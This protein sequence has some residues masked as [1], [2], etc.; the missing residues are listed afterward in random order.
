MNSTRLELLEAPSSD[1]SMRFFISN[2]THKTG[3]FT[4][5]SEQSSKYSDVDIFT[6][7]II[8]SLYPECDDTT[9]EQ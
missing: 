9:L 6:Y 1:S 7:H 4:H 2:A 3:L 5:D 8:I